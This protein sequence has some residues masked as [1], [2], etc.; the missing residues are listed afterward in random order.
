MFNEVTQKLRTLFRPEPD[1]VTVANKIPKGVICLISALHFHDITTQIPHAVSIAVSRGTEPP[2]RTPPDSSY[3]G[4]PAK[5]SLP[6]CSISELRAI[7]EVYA[8]AGS[9]EK[10]VRDFVA[11]WTKVITLDRFDI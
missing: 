7:A 5:H 6:A 2:R 4:F 11:A 1:L 3:T 10:L 8:E 9:N